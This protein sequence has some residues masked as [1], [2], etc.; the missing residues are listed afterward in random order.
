[1][2]CIISA[3]TS[4]G[5]SLERVT[6]PK[7]SGQEA[8]QSSES[9]S[10]DLTRLHGVCFIGHNIILVYTGNHFGCQKRKCCGKFPFG[11]IKS[12][13]NSG[14]FTCVWALAAVRLVREKTQCGKIPVGRKN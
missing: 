11:P 2:S 10:C 4:L 6:C 5:S 1:M 8:T 12:I 7:R 13:V 9:L 14:L 3:Q